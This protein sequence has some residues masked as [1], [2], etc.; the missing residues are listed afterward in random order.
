MRERERRWSS[1]HSVLAPWGVGNLSNPLPSGRLRRRRALA[2]ADVH[3]RLCHLYGSA[4]AT[5][6]HRPRSPSAPPGDDRFWQLGWH[7]AAPAAV[8]FP[9]L[10]G[11]V[12]HLVCLPAHA[13][14]VGAPGEHHLLP[15]CRLVCRCCQNTR[16]THSW[17]PRRGLLGRRTC[18][19]PRYVFS[20]F[21]QCASHPFASPPSCSRSCS[22]MTSSW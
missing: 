12:G 10:A 14:G 17:C 13:V 11:C 20:F 21:A 2:R 9:P 7:R 1:Y 3:H 8:L 5:P 22:C 6:H 18:S 15:S 4:P 16:L 19:R